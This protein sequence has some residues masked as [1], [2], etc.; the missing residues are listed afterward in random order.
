ML[1]LYT[2]VKGLSPADATGN[3]REDGEKGSS[4]TKNDS[5]LIVEI[6]MTY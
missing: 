3:V 4:V 5:T 2:E 6:Y 1:A